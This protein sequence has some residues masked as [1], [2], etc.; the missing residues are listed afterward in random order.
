MPN[1]VPQ[2]WTIQ[3]LDE[4]L[5][6]YDTFSRKRHLKLVAWLFGILASV[7]V[8]LGVPALLHHYLPNGVVLAVVGA[9]FLAL[10]GLSAY[11]VA[12]TGAFHREHGICCASCGVPQ[13]YSY[14]E[15]KLA[16]AKFKRTKSPIPCKVCGAIIAQ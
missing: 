2:P 9:L 16:L 5:A 15:G 7:F 13:T 11:I 14:V 8:V 6:H 4:R 3:Y 12:T 10:L 1:D